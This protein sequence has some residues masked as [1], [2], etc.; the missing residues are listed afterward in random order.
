MTKTYYQVE[1]KFIGKDD[2]QRNFTQHETPSSAEKMRRH[3]VK[4][5]ETRIVKVTITEEFVIG[6]DNDQS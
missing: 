3:F 1:V 2:W 5:A 6:V 4:M